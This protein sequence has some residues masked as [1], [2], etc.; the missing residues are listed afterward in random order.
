M[1]NLTFE[2]FQARVDTD[3]AYRAA[4]IA[5]PRPVLAEMGIVYPELATVHVV[6]ND[7]T[8]ISLVLG[9]KE[10]YTPKQLAAMPHEIRAVLT[11]SFVDPE[12]KQFLLSRP[13]DAIFLE[14]GYRVPDTTAVT[15]YEATEKD[16]YF[17]I[18]ATARKLNEEELSEL[19]LEQVAGGRPNLAA[20]ALLMNPLLGSASRGSLHDASE[21]GRTP[22]PKP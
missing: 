8:H 12:F 9:N 14:I 11:R 2:S 21:T 17:P 4:F 19:E 6:E 20:N 16:I 18:F 22:I 13:V 5:N 1:A 3:P 7:A 10:L 15:T